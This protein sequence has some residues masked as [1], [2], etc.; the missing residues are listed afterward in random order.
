MP[1]QLHEI[2]AVESGKEGYFRNALPEMVNL[3]K[4]KLDH[5]SAN[6]KTLTLFGDDTPEK[7]AKEAAEGEIKTLS[8]NVPHELD[9]LAGV[10][11]DYLDIII[12]KDEANTRA[13]S[14]IVIG[15]T[16]IAKDVPATTLL[17]L[18]N[19]F[20]QLRVVYEQIPTLQPGTV[21][22]LDPTQGENVYID[23]N[24]QIRSKTKKDFDFRV[25]CEATDKHP[26]QIEKWDVT[27]EIG[28]T[29]LTRWSGM[30]SVAQKSELLK[31]F[32]TLADAIKQ[33][34]QRANKVEVKTDATIGKALFDYLHKK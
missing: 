12:Q 29:T 13:K 10:T 17:A 26:A 28:F 24:K 30:I 27:K 9:Y 18:E 11:A 21:W 15:G 25:L 3:F 19:K 22:K 34:R 7:Q 5:F 32:D 14:D 4:N 1:T 31:R 2:L 23:D 8:T 20:K 16:V 6:V 33:A